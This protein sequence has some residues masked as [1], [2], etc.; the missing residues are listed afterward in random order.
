MKIYWLLLWHNF[1]TVKV[2]QQVLSKVTSIHLETF[3]ANA[4]TLAF[5]MILDQACL[6][7]HF[8]KYFTFTLPLKHTI[9]LLTGCGI[10][11]G[12]GNGT[13]T[14][15]GYYFALWLGIEMTF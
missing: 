13:G 5:A 14:G 3:T 9:L 10:L 1:F 2:G 6:F 4:V 15:N 11:T 8:S 12:I 7:F